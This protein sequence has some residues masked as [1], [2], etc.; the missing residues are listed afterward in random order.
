MFS[1]YSTGENRITSSILAV[2]ERLAIDRIDAILGALLEEDFETVRFQNQSAKDGRGV[3]DATI[4]ASFRILVETKVV[5]RAVHAEQLQR[6]LERLK[7]AGEVDRVMLLLTPDREE[8]VE[9][10]ALRTG[11]LG[12]ARLIWA[13]FAQ[14]DQAIDSVLDEAHRAISEREAFLLR[15]L[16]KTLAEEN[17]LLTQRDVLII[18]ARRAW[19]MYQRWAAYVCQPNR[20]FQD[21]QYVGF[22][23]DGEIKPAVARIMSSE[24]SVIFDPENAAY[25]AELRKLI[26]E[27][28]R[29][30]V[31]TAGAAYK[32]LLL[33][34]LNDPETI[35]LAAPVTNDLASD[36]GR[37]TAFVQN[38]RYVSLVRLKAA[39]R[40]SDLVASE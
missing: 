24:E 16:Q 20:S 3:P 4:A 37:T 36:S 12:G 31:R 38:Q 13:S 14:L 35:H 26:D 34:K 29:E 1:T 28:V 15:E 6:H 5:R 7:R 11:E 2:L 39:R 21:I 27:T 23:T 22:Y 33:S 25:G 8:P 19:P 32:V 10:R 40:T 30:G 9:V 17:L 18:P